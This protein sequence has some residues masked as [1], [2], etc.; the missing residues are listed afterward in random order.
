MRG[1]VT[2]TALDQDV[3]QPMTLLTGNGF[4]LGVGYM[5]HGGL[6]QLD[7]AFRYRSLDPDYQGE[8]SQELSGTAFGLSA[9]FLF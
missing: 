7:A 2:R 3:D 4:A 5:P 9:R 8:P 6:Y 1:G